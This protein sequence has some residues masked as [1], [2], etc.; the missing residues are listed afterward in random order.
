MCGVDGGSRHQ[1]L[2]T[3]EHAS[4]ALAESTHHCEEAQDEAVAV[5]CFQPVSCPSCVATFHTYWLSSSSTSFYTSSSSSLFVDTRQR[6]RAIKVA[7]GSPPVRQCVTLR[8]SAPVGWCEGL[9]CCSGADAAHAPTR[10][11]ALRLVAATANWVVRC[12]LCCLQAISVSLVL[13][14]Q[15]FSVGFGRKCE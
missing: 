1:L 8:G 5:Q 15:T 10:V 14:R 11:H 12:A 6:P 13:R 3:S 4:G 9:R 2:L 7:P